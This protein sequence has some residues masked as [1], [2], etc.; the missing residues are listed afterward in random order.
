M[1]HHECKPSWLEA[2]SKFQHPGSPIASAFPW[3]TLDAPTFLRLLSAAH[4]RCSKLSVRRPNDSR[5]AFHTVWCAWCRHYPRS[6]GRRC[7][8]PNKITCCGL[9]YDGAGLRPL[10]I[11]SCTVSRRAHA[12]EALHLVGGLQ[13]AELEVAGGALGGVAEHGP[14]GQGQRNVLAGEHG[15]TGT[16]NIGERELKRAAGLGDRSR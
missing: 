4:S 8:E 7:R 3:P 5:F 14:I 13:V 2:R 9:G 16:R 15:E 6:A 1:E 12:I 11:A 10:G